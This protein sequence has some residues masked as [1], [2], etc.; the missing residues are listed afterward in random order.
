MAAYE[1]AQIS[2]LFDRLSE[3]PQRLAIVT[4][5][6]G[7]MIEAAAAAGADTFLTGEGNH[8]TYHEAME[9]GINVIYAGH[10]GTETLGVRALAKRA[11]EHFGVEHAFFDVPT[12]L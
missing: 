3:R 11:A 2:T 8:P 1:R 5:G 7:S 10:Y 4:G 9:L 6:A 12:G